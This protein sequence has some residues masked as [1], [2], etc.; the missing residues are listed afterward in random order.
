MADKNYAL[1]K[2][3]ITSGLQCYKKLWFDVHQPIKKDKHVFRIGNLF[4]EIVR[5]NYAKGYGKVLDLS[6]DWT[7]AVGRT[8][9]FSKNSSGINL[10]TRTDSTLI[11]V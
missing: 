1:T 4:N 3:K 7:D 8:K 11:K 2:T 10:Y 9:N 6:D 5:K